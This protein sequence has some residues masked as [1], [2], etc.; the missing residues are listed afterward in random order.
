MVDKRKILKNSVNKLISLN[1]SDKEIIVNLKDVGISEEE[2][3]A[4]LEE[5][6]R[7][8]SGEIIPKKKKQEEK[9][10]EKPARPTPGVYEEVL[11]TFEEEKPEEKAKRAMEEIEKARKEPGAALSSAE[12]NKLWEKG[13]LA[14]VDARLGEMERLKK[15]IDAIIDKKVQEATEKEVKKIKALMDA[16]KTLLINKVDTSLAQRTKEITDVIDNRI[17]ELKR[18]S[19]LTEDSLAGLEAQKKSHGQLIAS[20]DEKSAS[21]EKLK[22]DLISDMNASLIESQSKIESFLK[23]SEKK[24]AETDARIN[25]TLQLE[26]KITEGLL[27]DA[28]Q[29]IDKMALEKS[30]ELALEV[31]TT[32]KEMK[33]IRDQID[34]KLLLSKVN[35][36]NELKSKLI[37]LNK[38]QLGKMD[39][40][41]IDAKKF[42]RAELDVFKKEAK[43]HLDGLFN[44]QMAS[45]TKEL[46]QKEKE[47]DE[48]KEQIDLERISATM[49]DLDVFKQ[50]FIKTIEKNVAEFNKAKRELAERMKKRDQAIE[51]RLKAID[52]KTAELTEFE[53]NF[54]AEMGL[55]IDKLVAEKPPKKPKPRR[56]K[57]K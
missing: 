26:S 55:T 22:S 29:K 46:R 40:F 28:Q 47:V 45:W 35:E 38:V 37:E 49:Q 42:N 56:R 8:L 53:K 4:I 51:Y 34:P 36:L 10:E 21:L 13:I 1:I 14:T 20:I 57:K 31:S 3:R 24:R 16:Q 19:K 18:V 50:Q 30:D 48:L 52:M 32:M 33:E 6:K 27:T 15:E 41:K 44:S 9:M 12:I 23:E 11:E 25:R 2:A 39:Q 54:A 17:N 7:E 5:T 43:L